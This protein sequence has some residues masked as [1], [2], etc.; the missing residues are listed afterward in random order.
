MKFDVRF[1]IGFMFG[2]YGLL[3]VLYGLVTSGSTAYERSFDLNVN[4][5][6]GTVLFVFGLVMLVGAFRNKKARPH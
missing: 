5:I 6:W 3:L 2:F 4:L 1:P